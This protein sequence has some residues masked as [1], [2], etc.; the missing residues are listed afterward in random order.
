MAVGISF[1]SWDPNAF[2]PNAVMEPLPPSKGHWFGTDDLG[3]DLLLRSVYG[4]RVSLLVGVVSVGISLCVGIVYG[5]VGGYVGGWTDAWMM[6]FL[7][8]FLAIPTIFLIAIVL[9][10]VVKPY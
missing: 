1:F 3:R 5:L 6:R 7:D 9:L 8:L 10:A 4:A 2:D